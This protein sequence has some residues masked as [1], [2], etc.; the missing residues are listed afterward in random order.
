MFENIYINLDKDFN[1]ILI[2]NCRCDFKY[3]FVCVSPTGEEFK[4]SGFQVGY[5]VYWRYVYASKETNGR[6]KDS[7]TFTSIED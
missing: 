6:G 4:I 7:S 3:I 2:Y 1:Q 5:C